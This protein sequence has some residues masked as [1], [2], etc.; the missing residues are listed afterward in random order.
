MTSTGIARLFRG[1]PAVEARLVRDLARIQIARSALA[2][3]DATP[4]P[5]TDSS[6]TV[7]RS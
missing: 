5:V 1:R 2:S 4:P 7:V 3:P 6:C